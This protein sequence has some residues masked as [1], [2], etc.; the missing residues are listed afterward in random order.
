[1]VY[2]VLPIFLAL[3]A[4]YS[5]KT[6]SSSSEAK[7]TNA[8]KHLPNEMPGIVRLDFPVSQGDRYACS[9]AIIGPN[10]VIS[11]N[12]CCI[13]KKG[14]DSHRL[15]PTINNTAFAG[16]KA[17]RRIVSVSHGD[18][19]SLCAYVYSPKVNAQSNVSVDLELGKQ[20]ESNPSFLVGTAFKIAGYPAFRTF[21]SPSS[22]P[23]SSRKLQMGSNIFKKKIIVTRKDKDNLTL[24]SLENAKSSLFC[25]DGV[26]EE[27][28]D[29][30]LGEQSLPNWREWGASLLR[31]S[32]EGYAIFGMIPARYNKFDGNNIGC[33]RLLGHSVYKGFFAEIRKAGGKVNFT[34]RGL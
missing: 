23:T 13:F 17:V 19:D 5:C 7:V 28:G 26:S 1:M 29:V 11:G 16:R 14:S 2:K 33:G 9:G 12:E 3:I 32:G 31:R 24:N 18:N 25:F 22:L 34:K 27:M 15:E 8:T 20:A 6:S 21:Y 4:S 30:Q 10:V